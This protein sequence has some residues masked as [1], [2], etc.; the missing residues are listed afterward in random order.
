MDCS[1]PF[2]ALV[3]D[4]DA[5]AFLPLL[6]PPPFFDLSALAALFLDRDEDDNLV[7]LS[8]VV[9]GVDTAATALPLLLPPA[10]ALFLE[11]A[12]LAWAKKIL[13]LRWQ[14]FSMEYVL[15]FGTMNMP[16]GDIRNIVR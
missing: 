7:V 11:P 1:G 16:P 15:P 2:L 3:G 12:C 8:A 13:A 10:A 4:W 5:D 14:Q 9:F 6:P